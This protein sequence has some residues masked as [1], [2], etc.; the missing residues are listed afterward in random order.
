MNM[1]FD[2]V[3][4]RNI[5][6][7]ALFDLFNLRRRLDEIPGRYNMTFQ[8]KTVDL[9]V[10][11]LMAYFV[12]SSASAPAR[13]VSCYFFLHAPHSGFCLYG[14]A[15]SGRNSAFMAYHAI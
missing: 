3:K 4:N 12:L 10:K 6:L 13:I 7:T 15:L 14:T 2:I 11:C 8:R 1:G 9:F 5:D